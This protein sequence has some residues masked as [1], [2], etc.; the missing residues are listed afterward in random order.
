MA[1]GAVKK[2]VTVPAIAIIGVVLG[3]LAWII[4]RGHQSSS[5][6]TAAAQPGVPQAQLGNAQGG[7]VFGSQLTGIQQQLGDL[8]QQIS[9]QGVSSQAPPTPSVIRAGQ[10]LPGA[11][12]WDVEHPGIPLRTDVSGERGNPQ[13]I[14]AIIPFGA[15]DVQ[16]TGPPVMGQWSMAPGKGV[17]WYYPVSW[18]GFRGFIAQNDFSQV[19]YGGGR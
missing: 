1:G 6:T 14:G 19:T 8:V 3:G 9:A 15:K 17:R 18:E 11:E 10:A 12:Q 13:N 5:G 4:W 2:K 16:I 7:D